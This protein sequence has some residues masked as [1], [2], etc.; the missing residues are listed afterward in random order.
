MKP[1]DANDLCFLPAAELAAGIRQRDVSPVE[2]VKAYLSR[3]EARNPS[4]NAYTLVLADQALDAARE[5]EKAVM[6]GRPL[7]PLARRSRRDQR[8]R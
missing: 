4:I 2:V 5:A 7:G 8:P 3:I 1:I 6:S